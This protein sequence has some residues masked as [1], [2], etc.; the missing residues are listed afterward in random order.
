MDAKPYNELSITE[1]LALCIWREARGEGYMGKRGVAH[2]IWNRSQQPGWWGH[3]IEQVILK[4]YQFSS[5]NAN[6]PNSSKWPEDE[7]EMSWCEC[8]QVA[9]AVL[10]READEQNDLTG[11]AVYYFSPPLT[12]PPKAW[13]NVEITLKLGNLTF[14]KPAPADLSSQGD[15]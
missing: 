8:K 11:G 7:N 4:P 1:L 3:T 10:S 12:E 14:C 5:F 15:V 2:V 6:D 13:G 9:E